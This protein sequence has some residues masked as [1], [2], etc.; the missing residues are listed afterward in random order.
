MK[1]FTHILTALAA[2]AMLATGCVNEDPAYKKNGGTTPPDPDA[3]GYLALAGMTMR[4]VTD[5]DTDTQPDDTSGETSRPEKTAAKTRA[6][7]AQPD[8]SGYL[9]EFFTADGESKLAAKYSE[10][11]THLN[12][13]GNLELPVG[14]YTLKVRSE[15]AAATP[16]VAWEHPVYAASRDF[17]VEKN[18]TT[19]LGEVICTLD[20]IKVTFSCS[21]DL[22]DKLTDATATTISLGETSTIFAKGETRAAYFKSRAETN[23]LKVHL[24]GAFAE[25]LQTPETPVRI[26]KTLTGVKAGQWRKIALVITYSDKGDIKLDIEVNDFVEDEEIVVPDDDSLLEPAYPTAPVLECPG[27]DLTRP[28]QLKAAMFDS[29]GNYTGTPFLFNLTSSGGIASFMVAITSDNSALTDRVAELGGPS[30]DLCM[31]DAAHPAREFLAGLGFPLG[32]EMKN[33]HI[34]SFDLAPAMKT[35]YPASE[36]THTFAFTMTD[37][38]GLTSRQSLTLVVDP[39][40]ENTPPSIVWVDHDIDQQYIVAADLEIDIAISTES[41]IKALEVTIDSEQLSP[42]LPEIGLPTHFDICN[43]DNAL[44]PI[45]GTGGLEFPINE[46]VKGKKNIQISISEFMKFLVDIPGEHNF[47]IKVTD[48]ADLATTKTVKLLT[49]Q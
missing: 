21:K 36:G 37:A 46:E 30:F 9:V 39:A 25:T 35:L 44:A 23:T 22:A 27:H 33:A 47:I 19:D 11:G 14:N 3:K 42:E 41:A 4:V 48:E 8:V 20:N 31:I 24:E 28:F 15:S 40:N 1:T 12:A 5:A 17:S 18:K 6:D 49:E 38:D 29:D 7:E 10:L 45:L 16:D 34:K 43:V 13:D 32:D 26:N 2:A